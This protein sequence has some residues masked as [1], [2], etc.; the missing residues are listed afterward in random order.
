MVA[1]LRRFLLL[2]CASLA[3]AACQS[4]EDRAERHFQS[5]MELVEAEEFDRAIVEFRNVFENLPQHNE[6]RLAAAELYARIGDEGRAYRNYLLYV[7]QNP[8][9]L[10]PRLELAELAIA[11]GNWEEL[12]RHGGKAQELAPD[13]P[14][15]QAIGAVMAYQLAVEDDAPAD[16]RD[17]ADRVRETR[18]S[19]SEGVVAD[20]VVIDN[21]L[22][23]GE[24][25]QAIEEID[26]VLAEDPDLERFQQLKLQVLGQLGDREAV[27]TQLQSLVE[28]YPDNEGYAQTLIQWYTTQG[29]LD[30]AEAFIRSRIVEGEEGVQLRTLLI[31]FLNQSKGHE[32]A[33]A[34]IDAA[35]EAGVNPDLFRSLRAGIAFDQGEREAAIAEMEEVVANAEPGDQTLGIKVALARMLLTDGNEVAARQQIEEVLATDETQV[36]AIKIRSSWLIEDDKTDEAIVTLRRA[37]DQAPSDPEIMTIMAQ[38]HLRNGSRGLAGEMFSL[39]LEASGNAP[40]QTANYVRFLLADQNYQVAE[41]ALI[42]S[43]RVA[44]GNFDVLVLLGRVYVAQEDWARVEQVEGTLRRLETQEGENAAN[45]LQVA[46]LRGQQGE[47]EAIAFLE[48]MAQDD[49]TSNPATVAI[50]RSLLGQ[51]DIEG[52]LAYVDERLSEDEDNPVLRLLRAGVLVAADRS[53]EA[54]EIYR[55][56][57]ANNDQTEGVWRALYL[58]KQRQGLVDEADAVLQEA[59]AA[60]PEAPNLLWALAGELERDGDIEGAIGIYEQL[61]GRLSGSPIV[62]NNLAS[63]IATYRD[64][65]EELERAY[66]V[67]RRLRGAEIPAFQDTYGW[68]AFR[69]GQLEDAL[70]HLE[71]AAAG[72]PGD[73]IVQYHYARALAAAERHEEAL[74]QYRRALEIAGPGDTRS[75]FETAK[76]EIDRIEGLLAQQ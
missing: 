52:A 62:A 7:E 46:R 47:D 40:E 76:D 73:P 54:D 43:L 45:S 41:N 8:E 38:A 17:A 23:D 16:R 53:A 21:L 63:L 37:L 49:Q 59:V 13:D 64:S 34:E 24:L 26:R 29:D 11:S 14:R 51:N 69:R 72:L 55:D 56:A 60:M 31:A 48:Q 6:A 1:S 32:A 70:E 65:D 10:P 5:A 12:R 19:L 25:R 22:R 27:Q 30:A 39:A 67:A 57:L 71:P 9:D 58:S 18:A 74:D 36:D 3:L 68:I 50:V 44:P 4:A 35:L 66:A 2:S 28:R 20:T 75:Q 61:Y 15:V 33:L 42:N